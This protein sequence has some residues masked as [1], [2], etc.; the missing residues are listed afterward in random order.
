ML[1]RDLSVPVLIANVLAWPLLLLAMRAHLNLYVH[2]IALTPAPFLTALAIT[3]LI[4]WVT[5]IFQ[6]IA[7]AR[8]NPSEVLH[9]E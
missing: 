1:L 7:A 8:V 3:V 2:R 5:V 4:A 6:A 9:Y